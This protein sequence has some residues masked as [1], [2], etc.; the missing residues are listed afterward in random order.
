[1]SKISWSHSFPQPIH[2]YFSSLEKPKVGCV[3]FLSTNAIVSR[4]GFTEHNARD[5][6]QALHSLRTRHFMLLRTCTNIA[7]HFGSISDTSPQNVLPTT[8]LIT[9]LLGLSYMRWKYGP[10]IRW[11]QYMWSTSLHSAQNK[12][13]SSSF[14]NCTCCLRI[15]IRSLL[16]NSHSSPGQLCGTIKTL[17]IKS[18]SNNL[19][20][21][22]R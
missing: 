7:K 13:A 8:C 14:V 10:F 21:N 18:S 4:R 3:C 9:F 12:T 2:F 15:S 16:Y 1:M 22:S 20:P 11:E 17:F 5:T 19:L 6:Q